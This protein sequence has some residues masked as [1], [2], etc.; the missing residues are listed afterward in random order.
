MDEAGQA[1]WPVMFMYPEAMQADSVEDFCESDTFRRAC[2]GCQAASS[3]PCIYICMC[4]T[5]AVPRP[6]QWPCAEGMALGPAGREAHMMQPSVSHSSDC[7][8][9]QPECCTLQCRDHLDV[10]FPQKS[11]G[12]PWDPS[13][14][15]SRGRLELWYLS[16]AATP[17]T[18]AELTEVRPCFRHTTGLAS[19]QPPT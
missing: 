3:S 11:S 12:L 4:A 7:S 8:Q 13:G 2:A 5:S 14:T 18:S 16:Y 6:C 15:Y 1:H 19:S 10:M 9:Q 17:L